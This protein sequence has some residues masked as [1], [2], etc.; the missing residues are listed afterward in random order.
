M[1]AYHI[2]LT[3]RHTK[4]LFCWNWERCFSVCLVTE[5]RPSSCEKNTSWFLQAAGILVLPER[6][7]YLFL[8]ILSLNR[9]K[10]SKVDVTLYLLTESVIFRTNVVKTVPEWQEGDSDKET[11]RTAQ[12]RYEGDGV[13]GP[14]FPLWSYCGWA[15]GVHEQEVAKNRWSV[16]CPLSI[17]RPISVFS[18]SMD[19]N[20]WTAHRLS[21]YFVFLPNIMFNQLKLQLWQGL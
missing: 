8:L 3:K 5:R 11:Q 14:N 19:W 18:L 20:C 15:E 16:D 12:V 4:M 10:I 13:V 9:K 7:I 1:F 21:G 2:T 6:C 17:Y